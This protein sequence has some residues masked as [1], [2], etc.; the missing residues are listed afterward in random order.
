MVISAG[1]KVTESICFTHTNET[2]GNIV[3]PDGMKIPC[4]LGENVFG[5][6]IKYISDSGTSVTIN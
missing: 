4:V 1:N 3:L 5:T 2:N 6:K